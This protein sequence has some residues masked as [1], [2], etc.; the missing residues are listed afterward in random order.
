MTP[1]ERFLNACRRK[2]VDTTPVWFMRQAGR[3]LPEY[4]RL[5]KDHS[6]LQ[7]AKT[8]NLSVEVSMMPIRAFAVDAAILFAD[9]MLPLEPMGVD[10]DIPDN[11]GPVI[12]T[13]VRSAD[14]VDRLATFN[15][16]TELG[17]VLET[18]GTLHDELQDERALIGF[19]GAPFTLAS[20]L[21]EGGPS[22]QF[23][24]T[25]LMMHR[26]PDVWHRLMDKLTVVVGDYLAAQL[27]AGADAV[28]VFDSWVGCLSPSDYQR[29][30]QPY[31][32]RVFDAVKES[33]APTI[34]FGTNTADL[35]SSM[36]QAGG[37]VIG[38]DW[39]T[40]LSVAWKRV[41]P[42]HAIQG[43]LDPAALAASLEAA[44][45]ETQAILED[46]AGRPG[47]IF[48][49]GHGVL[50]QTPPE[51]A[52]AIVDLVHEESRRLIREVAA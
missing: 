26:H 20:Y 7:L 13:P 3:F 29:F 2:P 52:K 35:L 39:R 6:I 27:R 48:N 36:A 50:P 43:N 14:D 22:R 24:E 34:H 31:T 19:S 37:D 49:L 45:Q 15:V 40:P 4:R 23:L 9:I 38:V 8:P 12:R 32:R 28:Q 17:F 1:R 11:E 42:N 25:K 47:H 51:N 21:I 16:P 10:L 46:V 18:V 33:G 5:R 30:V 41:G 44:K